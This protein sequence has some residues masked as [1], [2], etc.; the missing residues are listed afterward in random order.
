MS[1]RPC[2]AP[3]RL[4][5]PRR[6][7]SSAWS[8]VGALESGMAAIPVFLLWS[9]TSW[10]VVLVGAQIAVAHELDGILIH[11]TSS[12]RLDA[13][14]EQVAGVQIMVEATRRALSLR[15]GGATVNELARRFR[16]LPESVRDI[17]RRLLAAGLLRR[18][19]AGDFRLAC[20]PDRTSLRDVAGAIIGRPVD[21]RAVSLARSGR[22]L[23]ELVEGDAFLGAN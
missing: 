14:Q 1:I 22:S 18:S 15:D 13:Y 11:G 16:L 3:K 2:C 10:L 7:I 8:K 17:G 19:N 23:R 20:D 4:N 6:R 12:W 5:W 21:D 9:F